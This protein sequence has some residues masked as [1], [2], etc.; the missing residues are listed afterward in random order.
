[1][2]KTAAVVELQIFCASLISVLSEE[3]G[4]GFVSLIWQL[5]LKSC[6]SHLSDIPIPY[7]IVSYAVFHEVRSSTWSTLSSSITDYI[8]L[9]ALR[10][11]KKL[12]LGRCGPHCYTSSHATALH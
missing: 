3:L 10:G 8:I 1:M 7:E 4:K 12:E 11:C 2:R 5:S 6:I 9:T